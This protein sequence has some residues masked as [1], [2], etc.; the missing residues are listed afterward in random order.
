[1]DKYSTLPQSKLN[2]IEAKMAALALQTKL[3]QK[4]AQ[5]KQKL[6]EKRRIEELALALRQRRASQHEYTNYIQESLRPS[7]I[8]RHINHP[9]GFLPKIKSVSSIS[10]IKSHTPSFKHKLSDSS[11][12]FISHVGPKSSKKPEL[13]TQIVTYDSLMEE[14]DFGEFCKLSPKNGEGAIDP[15][16]TTKGSGTIQPQLEQNT[17]N[18]SPIVSLPPAAITNSKKK[19]SEKDLSKIPHVLCVD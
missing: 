13:C 8:K 9:E 2:A 17:Q 1:M 7:K 12:S 18:P 15:E 16:S 3:R 14:F 10:K 11:Q 19:K 5:H 4:R 6:E